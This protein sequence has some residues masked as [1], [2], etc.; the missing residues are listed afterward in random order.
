VGAGLIA[1]RLGKARVAAWSMIASAACSAV[2]GFA[3]GA[4]PWVLF[5]LAVV[6]GVA[7]VADS[8]LFS[9][10]VVENSS[11]D[12]VGTA[13]TVQMCTGFLLTMVSI[14]LIPLIASA[15]GWQ[16]AFLSFARLCEAASIVWAGF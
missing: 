11:R 14:R 12:Y 2:A 9:A 16:W 7:V 13:L 6:W 5:A 8:A 15:V 10:L 3:F 4:A 1:D